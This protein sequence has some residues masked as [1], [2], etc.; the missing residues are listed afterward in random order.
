MYLRRKLTHGDVK[1][2]DN[3]KI[4]AALNSMA[5]AVVG[6]IRRGK[7]EDRIR[8]IETLRLMGSRTPT[9]PEEAAEARVFIEA[10]I[11]LL[12]GRPM[13]PEALAEPYRGFYDKVVQRSVAPERPHEAGPTDE[14]REFLT[15][16]AAT[17][18]MVAKT[19]SDDDKKA[20]AAKLREI[21]AGMEEAPGALL[22]ALAKALEGRPVPPETLPAPY[23][24]FYRK[25][26]GSINKPPR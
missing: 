22:E 7:P 14:V 20:L 1:M 5:N 24:G 16:L 6:A 26:V 19:G 11:S 13:A 15:Q 9:V 2:T 3:E 10:L 25:V 4:A 18:V 23:A 17:A 8:L 21:K 12:E